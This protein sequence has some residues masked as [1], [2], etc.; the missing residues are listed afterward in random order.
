MYDLL[1]KICKQESIHFEENA[2]KTIVHRS[3][4]SIRDSL[5]MLEK[6]IINKSVT[7]KDVE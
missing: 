7:E 4:G 3:R 6:C 2:L 1:I 5:T